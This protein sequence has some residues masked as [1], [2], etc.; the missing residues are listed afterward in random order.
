MNCGGK[1]TVDR[2]SDPRDG[3]PPRLDASVRLLVGPA[4]FAG[5]G[6]RW[7]R[8][9]EERVPATKATSF[10]FFKGVLDLPVDYGVPVR[11]YRRN[12][13]WQLNFYNHVVRNYTHVLLEAAR[14]IFGPLHGPD[15]SF[16]IPYLLTKGLRVG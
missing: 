9:L 10:A 6:T 7:A 16:E 5:Q 1:N 11:T 13:R 4:N 8:A 14:P 15:G 2:N 3:M 12:P